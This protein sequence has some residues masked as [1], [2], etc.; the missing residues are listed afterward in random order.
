M[1]PDDVKA[2]RVRVFGSTGAMNGVVVQKDDLDSAD[3]GLIITS[4]KRL[5]SQKFIKLQSMKH[6]TLGQGTWQ[7]YKSKL[8]GVSVYTL[9]EIQ[10]TVDNTVRTRKHCLTVA[11]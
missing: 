3:P 2:M 10:A 8:K 11:S 9:K 7:K 4:H 1:Y 6:L 5:A